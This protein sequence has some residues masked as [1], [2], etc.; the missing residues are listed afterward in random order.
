MDA[1]PVGEPDC[2]D[3]YYDVF[4][5]YSSKDR[6]WVQSILIPRFRKAGLSYYVDYENTRVGY[7]V[8]EEI[9]KAMQCS[10]KSIAI[11]TPEFLESEWVG[12]EQ[13]VLFSK[14]KTANKGLVI[15][16]LLKPCI[17]P[18][19]L[20]IRAHVN[21]YDSDDEDAEWN[22]LLQALFRA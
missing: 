15:P 3:T 6:K 22:K 13:H 5:S 16:V 14:D 18:P 21:L 20:D 2:I 8:I 9:T 12:Y 4:I 1:K 11:L 7:S 19:I 10:R 17:I